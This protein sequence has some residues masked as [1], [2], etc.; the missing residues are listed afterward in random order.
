MANF[1]DQEG[2]VCGRD[3]CKGVIAL[4]SIDGCC[5]C[6]INPPCG[7][8][9]TPKEYCPECDWDAEEEERSF[10]FNGTRMTAVSKEDAAKGMYSSTP[11]QSYKP[12]PLDPTKIDYHIEGHTHFTQKCVGVFPPGTT[13]AAVEAKVKGTFGGRFNSFGNGRFEYIAYTD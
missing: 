8:C 9:T 2:E 1:G 5:S 6:H 3:G 13:M 11:I 12:R 7:Y 10:Y 4:R